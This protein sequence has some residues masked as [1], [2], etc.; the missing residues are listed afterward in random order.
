[1][2]PLSPFRFSA[3]SLLGLLAGSFAFCAGPPS[4]SSQPEPERDYRLFVGLD[5]EVSHDEHY[6]VIEGYVNNRVRTA[7]ASQLV[8]LRHVDD[9]RF[10][11]APK[12]SRH[13]LII[14]NLK[15]EKIASTAKAAR[16]ALRN[17]QAL[18]G[19]QAERSSQ[20][21][22]E[23]NQLAQNT[24]D[25]ES[26]EFQAQMMELETAQGNFADMGSKMT[27]QGTLVEDMDRRRSSKEPNTPK[28]LLI[29][30][31]VTSPI[32]I[33]DAYLIGVARISTE[34]SVGND[35]IFFDRIGRL[36]PKSRKIDVIK[37][38]L[39]GEFKVLDVKI[40]IY[41][42]GQELVTDKSEKQFALTREEA[43]EYLVLDRTSKNRGKSLGAEPVW[44]L[45]PAE[46]FSSTKAEAY[47]FPMTVEVDENGKVT[48]IDPATILPENVAALVTDLP[49]F[50]GL[51]DGIAVATTARVNLA[52][53]F[54]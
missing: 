34:E 13:A 8:S 37:E 49:F 22:N 18:Q 17:Q 42:N 9:F 35:V 11:Y 33:S 1:M 5:V 7:L 4:I 39:P 12:L 50:P 29:T 27:D 41:R 43:F 26:Q 14:E 21:Q 45:A 30:A 24:V 46:L 44:A 15:A 3:I 19:F 28:A 6:S 53:F 38:G 2:S 10:I 31:K 23:I 54:R 32:E 25:T 40:H 52:N 20:L 47:D 16:D 36:G 48:G 51:E